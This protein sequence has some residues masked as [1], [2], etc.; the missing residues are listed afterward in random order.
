[1]YCT[2]TNID[3]AWLNDARLVE[4]ADAIHNAGAPLE[5]WGFVD[6]TVRPC[7]K[8]GQNQKVLHNDHKRIHSIKFQSVVAPNGLIAQLKQM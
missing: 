7:S 6:G 1:M 8:P 4:Y 5:N 2:N 3:Q